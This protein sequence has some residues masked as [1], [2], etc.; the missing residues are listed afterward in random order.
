MIKVFEYP[1]YSETEMYGYIS[2][3]PFPIIFFYKVIEV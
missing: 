1:T 2:N 3:P